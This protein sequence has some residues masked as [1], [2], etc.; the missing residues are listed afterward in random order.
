MIEVI[1]IVSGLLGLL[2]LYARFE[3]IKIEQ[4]EKRGLEYADRL[5]KMYD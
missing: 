2:A 4:A 5:R 3:G 1:T